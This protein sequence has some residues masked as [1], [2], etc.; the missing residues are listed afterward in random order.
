MAQ[1]TFSVILQTLFFGLCT[2]TPPTAPQNIRHASYVYIITAEIPDRNEEEKVYLGLWLHSF[3]LLSRSHW[4]RAAEN[5]SHQYRPGSRT[6]GWVDPSEAC[7]WWPDTLPRTSD[8]QWEAPQLPSIAL[9]GEGAHTSVQNRSLGAEHISDLSR[10]R[11]K[12]NPCQFTSLAN[13]VKC[14]VSR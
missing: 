8:H 2:K 3:S 6:K 5:C 4:K 14:A 13:C 9:P 7:P 11:L 1:R 12:S 10:I